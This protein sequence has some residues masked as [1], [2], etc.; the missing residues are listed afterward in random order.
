MTWQEN[1]IY[2]LHE[3]CEGLCSTDCV[4]GSVCL[5]A[6]AAS[7]SAMR[8]LCLV[9]RKHRIVVCHYMRF[10]VRASEPEHTD[11]RRRE[12]GLLS[13]LNLI[14]CVYFMEIHE[15]DTY[16]YIR[17][18][19]PYSPRSVQRQHHP[20]AYPIY[21]YAI[22]SNVHITPFVHFSKNSFKW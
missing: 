9:L 18:Y 21:I 19:I 14:M 17:F 5:F 7:V 1:K 4:N 6:S 8:N 16:T 11:S 10:S 15:Q 22:I 13:P 20:N 12:F 2:C 3:L